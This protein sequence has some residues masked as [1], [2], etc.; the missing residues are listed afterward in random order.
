MS[1]KTSQ[2][3]VSHIPNGFTSITPY[4]MVSDAILFSNFL[5]NAFDAEVVNEHF[6]ND[7]LRH[8]AYRIF[9]SI[10]EA[11]QS[12][13]E[14]SNNKISIHLYVPDCDAV[15]AKAIEAG[16]KSIYEVS[17][18]PYGERSGGV[19]DICGNSWWIATQ[20]IDMYPNNR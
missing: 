2:K 1:T 4:F 5:H 9:D 20:Q 13:E 19:E 16:G 11:S 14:F 8:G 15:Y 18:M 7:V 6:E 12:S 3:T 10:I 17:D